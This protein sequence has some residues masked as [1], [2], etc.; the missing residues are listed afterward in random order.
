MSHPVD[1]AAVASEATDLP[2]IRPQSRCDFGSDSMRFAVR[3]DRCSEGKFPDALLLRLLSVRWWA[4]HCEGGLQQ[5]I[6]LLSVLKVERDVVFRCNGLDPCGE[7]VRYEG[8]RLADMSIRDVLCAVAVDATVEL[9]V[10]RLG[11]SWNVFGG[12]VLHRLTSGRVRFGDIDLF[13]VRLPSS[14][15][16][17]TRR[18]WN[19]LLLETAA[20]VDRIQQQV[21]G[22][23]QGDCLE[24]SKSPRVLGSLLEKA[25][26]IKYPLVD[27]RF[28]FQNNLQLMTV[29]N[30]AE[31]Q[32]LEEVDVSSGSLYALEDYTQIRYLVTLTFAQSGRLLAGRP[33]K[34]QLIVRVTDPSHHNVRATG[35]PR[36]CQ[37]AMQFDLSCCAL[38]IESVLF[39]ATHI[40]LII[41]SPTAEWLLAAQNLIAF[42]VG[43]FQLM[44]RHMKYQRRGVRIVCDGE[45]DKLKFRRA[46]KL[47]QLHD[48]CT[49]LDDQRGPG[50][51][52][53]T[54]QERE[55]EDALKQCRDEIDQLEEQIQASSPDAFGSAAAIASVEV[56]D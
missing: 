11:D 34:I 35:L 17:T 54:D 37:I 23:E 47:Q 32:R 28:G 26:H 9:L 27:D 38:W 40:R 19:M 2:V 6:N 55:N 10:A 1:D 39:D 31:L 48:L 13:S 52:S 12:Y 21:C 30:Q 45:L 36:P 3:I 51:Q 46:Q 20:V 25:I 43:R 53:Q 16:L 50:V 49:L 29:M 44:R 5:V 56:F 42:Q 22:S 41:C 4:H 15:S 14:N 8:K 18:E 33:L 24:F 7:A